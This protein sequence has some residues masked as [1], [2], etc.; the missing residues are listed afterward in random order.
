MNMNNQQ[1]INEVLES[2]DQLQP[3]EPDAFLYTKILQKIRSVNE[4]YTPLKLVWLAAASFLLLLLLNV[5]ALRSSIPKKNTNAVEELANGYQL[6]NTNAI[7]YND[8]EPH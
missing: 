5:Q 1:K 7:N 2:L 8:H 4:A 6:L 3:A